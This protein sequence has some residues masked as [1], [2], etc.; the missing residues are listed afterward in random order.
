MEFKPTFRSFIG[1][2]LYAGIPILVA[3]VMTCFFYGN[4]GWYW[5]YWVMDGF[6][7]LL[8]LFMLQSAVFVHRQKLYLDEVG[9]R[10]TSPICTIQMR[11]QDVCQGILRQRANSISRTDQM[12]V[13]RSVDGQMLMFQTSIL[14]P[15]DE[16]IV[17][18]KVREKIRLQLQSDA[19]SM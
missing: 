13:L 2:V 4:K 7:A 14:D 6:T 10:L 3:G 18:K 8:F 11:W 9:I 5:P 17:L 1:S 12:I 15:S 19:P 16:T